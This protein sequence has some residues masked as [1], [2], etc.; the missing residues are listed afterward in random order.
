MSETVAYDI[1]SILNDMRQEYWQGLSEK[2]EVQEE[3]IE[4]I[5]FTLGG[6]EYAFETSYASEVI[7]VPKLVKLPG[8]STLIV[9]VFN[10]RG[11]IIAAMDIRPMLGLSQPTLTDTA[12]I[13]VIKG[14][15]FTTAI[16]TE[17]VLGVYSL[18][19]EK[20][21][22]VVKSVDPSAREFLRGQI[23]RD[24]EMTMLL[25]ITRLLDSPAL[26]INN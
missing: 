13:I 7:R 18:P 3:L 4:C 15:K 24:T 10:L 22:P 5:T 25:D 1:S 17:T 26:V 2:T 6:E 23:N 19:L 21:E 14:K 8:Q 9:G 16:L 11:E 20:F 12:R